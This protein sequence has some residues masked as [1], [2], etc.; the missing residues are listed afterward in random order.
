V[1]LFPQGELRS[2]HPIL[3]SVFWLLDS[4]KSVSNLNNIGDIQMFTKGISYWSFEGGLDGSKPA[5]EALDNAKETGFES[6]ELCL[7]ETGDVSLETTEKGAKEIVQAAQDLEIEISSV[8]CGLFWGKSLT[9]TDTKVRA[10]AVEIGKKLLDVAAWLEVDA[11][12]VVPGSV[13]VFFDSGSEVIDFGEAYKRASDS[14]AILEPYAKANK[15]AIG[16]ENVWNKF[17]TGPAE[18]AMFID[19]FK[20]EWVGSY[21]D[22]GNCLL[23]G[24]PE[25]WIKYLGSRIKRVHFK[26]FRRAV[27]TGAGFVDLLSGDVN[28]PAVVAALE[29]VDYNGYVTAEMIPLYNHYPE[30]LVYNTS[31]AMDAILSSCKDAGCCCCGC[32]HE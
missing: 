32:E 9:A 15:V 16:V 27:G 3:D 20:S 7:S 17:L 28:W 2:K 11:V 26:D 23:Y 10:E 6:L 5:I 21:F 29:E 1:V 13:D 24:Y 12:L 31:L 18:M 30:V 25:H 14:I 8:A 22:V 19:Q 4:K